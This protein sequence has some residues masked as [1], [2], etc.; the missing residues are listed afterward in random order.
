MRML[1]V[2]PEHPYLPVP[3][4]HDDG[5]R[6]LWERDAES[7]RLRTAHSREAG[8]IWIQDHEVGVSTVRKDQA[9]RATGS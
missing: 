2:P 6:L 7:G 1:D 3:A 4:P 8:A 9:L 5:A